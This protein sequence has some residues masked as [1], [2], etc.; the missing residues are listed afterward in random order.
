MYIYIMRH[1][2]TAWNKAGKIQGSS[3]ID[4][5]DEGKELAELSGDGF[6]RDGILFDRIYTS[7]LSRAMETARIV[8]KKAINPEAGK[9][10]FFVDERLR[11][12]CFGKYEGQLLKKLKETD[13]NIVRCFSKPS[14]YIPDPTGES[15]DHLFGRIR[16]FLEEVL[17]PLEQEEGM[18]RVLVLCHGTVIRAFLALIKGTAL[19][20]FWNTSQPNCSINKIELKDGK[21]TCL[22]ERIFYYES[23]DTANR[24]IL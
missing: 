17:R 22:Q 3:D 20:D 4:L 8:E 16:S 23:G 18:D 9:P 24:G 6:L 10:S 12:M 19:D 7:P 13:E 11:E 21:F 5:T 15:Y 2:E 14:K 1:G